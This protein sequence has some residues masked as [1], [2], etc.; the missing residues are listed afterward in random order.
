MA[1]S[2]GYCIPADIWSCDYHNQ[3][4]AGCQPYFAILWWP[5]MAIIWVP[6]L[7]ILMLKLLCTRV[8]IVGTTYLINNASC[9][10]DPKVFLLAVTQGKWHS[11][12]ATWLG[13]HMTRLCSSFKSSNMMLADTFVGYFKMFLTKLYRRD[14]YDHLDISGCQ[15][16]SIGM[17]STFD[18]TGLWE[19]GCHGARYGDLRWN[20]VMYSMVPLVASW[21]IQIIFNL[22]IATSRES[23]SRW[24]GPVTSIIIGMDKGVSLDFICSGFEAYCY[25]F[26]HLLI[27]FS[28]GTGANGTGEP[29][30][31]CSP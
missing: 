15:W 26:D 19:S 13:L 5:F 20:S 7:E 6:I 31:H 27:F 23:V 4:M 25:D 14:C 29:M 2:Y 28:Y 24:I 8:V 1:P 18:E 11:G 9:G 17:S 3:Y 21:Y 22:S 16:L 30:A 12:W 10:K